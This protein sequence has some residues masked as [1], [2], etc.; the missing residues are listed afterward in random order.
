MTD[1]PGSFD[2]AE[3]NVYIGPPTRIIVQGTWRGPAGPKPDRFAWASVF[4]M[5]DVTVT[6]WSPFSRNTVRFEGTVT[7]PTAGELR[8]NDLLDIDVVEA[9]RIAG[10]API[11]IPTYGDP[12]AIDAMRR[13]AALV[14]LADEVLALRARIQAAGS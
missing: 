11:L 5:L 4:G 1:N 3:F 14:V 8:P 13:A 7:G 6:T 12:A 10:T 9:L 2:V